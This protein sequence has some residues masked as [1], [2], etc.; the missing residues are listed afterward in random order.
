MQNTASPFYQL[1]LLCS[2]CPL[3]T[4][5]FSKD[6]NKRPEHTQINPDLTHANFHEIFEQPHRGNE[7]NAPKELTFKDVVRNPHE[8]E[9]EHGPLGSVCA[10]LVSYYSYFADNF[11]TDAPQQSFRHTIKLFC[12]TMVLMSDL[13]DKQYR[14]VRIDTYANDI[15]HTV[16]TLHEVLGETGQ[17]A[18]L[19]TESPTLHSLFQAVMMSENLDDANVELGINIHHLLRTAG[20]GSPLIADLFT[21]LQRFAMTEITNVIA[22]FQSDAQALLAVKAKE[23][24]KPANTPF[25][26]QLRQQ[27]WMCKAAARACRDF[28]TALPQESFIEHSHE[29]T[30]ILYSLLD[31]M[32]LT[33]RRL[34]SQKGNLRSSDRESLAHRFAHIINLLPSMHNDRSDTPNISSFYIAHCQKLGSEEDQAQFVSEAFE[35]DADRLGLFQEFFPTLEAHLKASFEKLMNSLRTYTIQTFAERYW[36]TA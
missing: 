14:N 4:P 32:S 13:A 27:A 26:R 20:S 35:K 17:L 3:L 36:L 12:N 29:L 6:S 9:R 23:D 34:A 19:K 21:Q 31:A 25:V 18:Q 33:Y 22:H 7:E 28:E 2:L 10:D 15:I 1:L 8:N 16:R 5:L 24:A 11:M 30:H